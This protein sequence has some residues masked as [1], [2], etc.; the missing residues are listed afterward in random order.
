MRWSSPRLEQKHKPIPITIITPFNNKVSFIK[1]NP[2]SSL[3][4][5]LAKLAEFRILKPNDWSFEWARNI[6]LQI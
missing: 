3:Y 2:T 5:L 6:I 4:I 1:T